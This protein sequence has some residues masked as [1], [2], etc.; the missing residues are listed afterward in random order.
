MS[1]E[2]SP[3][4]LT[5]PKNAFPIFH[6]NHTADQALD[7]SYLRFLLEHIITHGQMGAITS[8]F[9]DTFINTCLIHF[10]TFKPCLDALEA[11]KTTLLDD[12]DFFLSQLLRQGFLDSL[13]DYLR[14]NNVTIPPII[15]A[16]VVVQETPSVTIV[17]PDPPVPSAHSSSS[18]DLNPFLRLD[19]PIPPAALLSPLPPSPPFEPIEPLFLNT[20]FSASPTPSLVDD[21]TPIATHTPSSILSQRGRRTPP[22]PPTPNPPRHFLLPRHRYSPT[23]SSSGSSGRSRRSNFACWICGLMSHTKANCPQYQCRYC[24]RRAPGHTTT[25]CPSN[26]N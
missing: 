26:P 3:I 2:T 18:D 6:F 11:L 15:P 19:S 24:L 9:R 4:A 7:V 25:H 23:S 16:P 21:R 20:R 5:L 1:Q 10:T 17:P 8:H 14:D 22:R 13:L 12:R